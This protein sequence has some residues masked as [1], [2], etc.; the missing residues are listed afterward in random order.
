MPWQRGVRTHWPFS[1]WLHFGAVESLTALMTLHPVASWSPSGTSLTAALSPAALSVAPAMS[2]PRCSSSSLVIEL[3]CSWISIKPSRNAPACN[4]CCRC[5]SARLSV[6]ALR[7]ACISPPAT[8]ESACRCASRP[9]RSA[10]ISAVRSRRSRSSSC[11]SSSYPCAPPAGGVPAGA[12]AGAPAAPTSAVASRAKRGAN[13]TAG[14]CRTGRSAVPSRGCNASRDADGEPGEACIRRPGES[15]RVGDITPTLGDCTKA[16]C[17][18]PR[19][20]TA[21]VAA[22]GSITIEPARGSDDERLPGSPP[23]CTGV[24]TGVCWPGV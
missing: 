23:C 24:A 5:A 18:R 10:A 22:A 3:R 13:T 12:P 15:T 14:A 6:K 7:D 11:K 4:S 19:G 21:R 17:G 20:D 16:P 2:A 1:R 8:S 9:R